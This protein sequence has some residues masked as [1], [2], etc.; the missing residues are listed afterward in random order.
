LF[1]LQI[2]YYGHFG[3]LNYNSKVSIFQYLGLAGFNIKSNTFSAINF[4]VHESQQTAEYSQN[5]ADASILTLTL[6]L[7]TLFIVPAIVGKLCSTKLKRIKPIMRILKQNL[8]YTD[9]I[10]PITLSSAFP[11]FFIGWTHTLL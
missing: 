9:I 11:I 7:A 1:L 6:V 3:L 10:A 8:V 5:T 4:Q 2:V